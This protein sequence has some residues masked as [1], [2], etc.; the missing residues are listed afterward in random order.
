MASHS[1][2]VVRRGRLWY[3]PFL[4]LHLLVWPILIVYANTASFNRSEISSAAT[5][6]YFGAQ[7]IIDANSTDARSVHAADLDGDGDPD[8]VA[9][10]RGNSRIV[11]YE[12]LNGKGV[13][14]SANE[15]E[16]T[17]WSDPYSVITADLDNDDDLDV[18]AALGGPDEVVWY[19]NKLNVNGTFGTSQLINTPASAGA[20]FIT[21]GNMDD[22]NDIDV[23][24]A[25]QG[26]SENDWVGS[27]VVWYENRIDESLGWVSHLV[28][29]SV[30]RAQS[31]FA[32]DVDGDTDLDFLA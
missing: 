29:G 21:V 9:A 32:A 19:E 28:D 24:V 17:L 11:W 2:F 5:S 6:I 14:G 15:I 1:D 23:L 22:D 12:N 20:I 10:S 7:Q 4:V 13:F 25:H 18:L 8:V 27:K 16:T 30:V 3:R 31:V 26:D